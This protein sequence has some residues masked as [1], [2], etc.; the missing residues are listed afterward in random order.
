MKNK[1]IFTIPNILSFFRLCLL[2]CIVYFYI[3]IKDYKLTAIL[4]I[5]SGITDVLDGYIARTFNMVSD[6]GKILDPIADKA[7]QAIV[8]LCLITRF[9]WLIIPFIGILIKE[10]FMTITGMMVIKKTGEVYSAKWHG[11]LATFML[12]VMIIIH[13]IFYNIPYTFSYT[14]MIISTLLILLSFYNYAKD[15]CTILKKM[16]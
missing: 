8:L 12:D 11:K 10:L 13:I 7:T 4:L 3:N 16:S 6:L 15:N 9:K 14:L 1:K 2:P 5:I